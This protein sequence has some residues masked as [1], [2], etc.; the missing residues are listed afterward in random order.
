MVSVEIELTEEQ[1]QRIREELNV[2][3]P[4]TLLVCAD[5]KENLKKA[6]EPFDIREGTPLSA[7]AE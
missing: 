5:S 1:R 4:P 2:D 6:L 7:L 3:P